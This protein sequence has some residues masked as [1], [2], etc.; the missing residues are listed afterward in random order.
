[1]ICKPII[2]ALVQNSFSKSMILRQS[3][4]LLGYSETQL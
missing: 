4:G 3:W 1:M 2:I